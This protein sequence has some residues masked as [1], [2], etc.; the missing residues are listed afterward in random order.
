MASS[1][2][3]ASSKA[4]SAMNS[5]NGEADPRDRGHADQ[6]RRVERRPGAARPAWPPRAP[7]RPR[8]RASLPTTSPSDHAERHAGSPA[9][10]RARSPLSRT[11]AFA[12][13]NSGTITKLVHGSSACS[14]RASG[15]TASRESTASR[16]H[17]GVGVGRLGIVVGLVGRP[18]GL[19]AHRARALE[20]TRRASSSPSTTPA[21]VGCTPD[22]YVASHTRDAERRRRRARPRRRRRC[23]TSDQRARAPRP[24]AASPTSRRRPSRTA[25]SP[26]SRRC[27]RRSPA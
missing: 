12:S 15:E 22:S 7:R 25:R 16:S 26:R 4:S 11:P 20:R 24:R 23:S 9:R 17:W 14:I 2:S 21:I 6:V 10:H 19:S 1:T 3:T 13:A 18:P 5:A 8:S 27:R